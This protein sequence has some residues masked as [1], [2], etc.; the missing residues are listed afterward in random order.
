MNEGLQTLCLGPG[1]GSEAV[2]PA[3][4]RI[5]SGLTLACCVSSRSPLPSW[6]SVS[7]PE[8]LWGGG[9]VVPEALLSA[10]SEFSNSTKTVGLSHVLQVKEELGTLDTPYHQ[11][12]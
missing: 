7:L 11:P 4:Q 1:G 3:D 5:Y 2:G 8:K 10:A 9:K 6:A 12:L